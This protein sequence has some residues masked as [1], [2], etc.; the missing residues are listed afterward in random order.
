[1]LE[2]ADSLRV[3]LATLLRA[4]HVLARELG[5]RSDPNL[6]ARRRTWLKALAP[7]TEPGALDLTS[8]P[9]L[10]SERLIEDVEAFAKNLQEL[11]AALSKTVASYSVD[12]IRRMDLEQLDA[13]WREAQ[14]KF[15]PT[16]VF[17]RRKV[18]KLLQTYADTGA[19]DPQSELKV[20]FKIRALDV[21]IRDSAVA[22][23]AQTLEG[24]DAA[25]ATEAVRQTIDF[26][27]VLAS[28]R[29]EIDDPVRFESAV[30]HLITASGGVVLDALKAYLAAEGA[31]AET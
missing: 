14:T 3:A 10:P 17:A 26:R 4:E 18:R 30:S 22:P 12:A 24:P 6:E 28:L 31:V 1:M 25:R 23:V 7:R 5:L 13:A 27:P 9:D 11:V 19:A 8:V 20:L 21:R 2:A 15:W 16:S 29:S